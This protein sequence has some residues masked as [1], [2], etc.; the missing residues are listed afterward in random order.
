MCASC[1]R[2]LESEFD[3]GE[4]GQSD[5]EAAGLGHVQFEGLDSMNASIP[6]SKAMQRGGDVLLAYRM[7]GDEVPPHHGFPLRVIVPGH[8]GVRSVKHLAKLRVSPEEASGTWQQGMAYKGFNPSIKSTHGVVQ[9]L[10]FSRVSSAWRQQWSLNMF[11][12]CADSIVLLSLVLR[13]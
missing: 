5:Y 3:S 4:C 13:Y 2:Q 6:T 8:V 12:L 9:C 7:N 10:P 1:P 11:E